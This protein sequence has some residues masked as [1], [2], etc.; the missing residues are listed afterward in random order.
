MTINEAASYLEVSRDFVERRLAELGARRRGR[1]YR[2]PDEKVFE[3]DE[4]SKIVRISRL[5][6]NASTDKAE[7]FAVERARQRRVMQ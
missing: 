3:F 7:R 4:R 5:F 1:V 2:I 6:F